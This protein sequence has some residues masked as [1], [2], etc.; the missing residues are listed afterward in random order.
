ML[1]ANFSHLFY[2]RESIKVKILEISFS[3]SNFQKQ[4]LT[5]NSTWLL[6]LISHDSVS[7]FCYST[8]TQ[9]KHNW[10]TRSSL[11]VVPKRRK[12]DTLFKKLSLLFTYK[13]FFS[14]RYIYSICYVIIYL[15]C[16]LFTEV[17]KFNNFT[18]YTGLTETRFQKSRS[19]CK[20]NLDFFSFFFF[21]VLS[22]L[23]RPLKR[24]IYNYKKLF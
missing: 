15:L 18:V 16:L 1:F 24:N 20:I 11:V 3:V 10:L 2:T 4:L 19:V 8:I 14:K 7:Y 13:F 21:F 6:E 22:R 17:N 12:N 23:S 5:Y 9:L